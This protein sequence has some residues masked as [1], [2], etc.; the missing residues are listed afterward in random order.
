[1]KGFFRFFFGAALVIAV[2]F[3]LLKYFLHDR[4]QITDIKKIQSLAV[5]ERTARIANDK[6]T[7]D[8]ISTSRQDDKITN[9]EFEKIRELFA[10]FK[11]VTNETEKSAE[12]REQEFMQR[13]AEYIK[14]HG[15]EKVIE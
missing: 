6:L 12:V 11:P 15:N 4:A 9:Q 3:F 8:L 13:K 5:I 1:M 14:E 7:L 10:G 2:L